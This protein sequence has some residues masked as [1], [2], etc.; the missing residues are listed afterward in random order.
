MRARWLV[1]AVGCVLCH[2]CE[3]EVE[4][5]PTDVFIR[6]RREYGGGVV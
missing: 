5:T 1:C 6:R 4:D 2:L 3:L